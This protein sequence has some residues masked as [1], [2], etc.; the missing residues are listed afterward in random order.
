MKT[1]NKLALTG[2]AAAAVVGACYLAAQMMSDIAS[3]RILTL[4]GFS[5]DGGT[6]IYPLTF[7]LRDMVHKVAGKRAARAVVFA[8]AGANVVMALLFYFVAT[9]PAD[10]SVGAQDMFGAVLAPVWRIVVAS[11]AAEVVSELL[12]TEVYSWAASKLGERYQWAR[13]LASNSVS[14]PV[15]SVAFCWIAFAGVLPA[16]VVWSV[17][18]SNI[19][20]KWAMTLLS[21]P[22]IYIVPSTSERALD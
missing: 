16:P 14:V 21:L 7:T 15:D 5:I 13:V 4:F 10:P 6:L 8:A 3:L 2:I 20:V 19:L 18:A 1:T 9:L 17:V 11:I 22:A 12:D